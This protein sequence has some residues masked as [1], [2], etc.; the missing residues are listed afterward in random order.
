VQEAKTLGLKFA[1]CPWI[2]HEEANFTEADVKRAAA[3]FNKIGEA[4]KNAGITFAYHCHGY[5]FRPVTEGGSETLFDVLVRETKPRVC[6]L[7]DGRFL[8]RA[9]GQDRRSCWQNIRIAGR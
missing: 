7:P 6:E 2:P 8:G 4:F 3:D 1:V 9:S 5:E